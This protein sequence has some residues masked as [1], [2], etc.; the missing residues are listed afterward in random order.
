[1]ITRS[2]LGANVPAVRIASTLVSALLLLVAIGL[3]LTRT[4][5]GSATSALDLLRLGTTLGKPAIT[6][7]S[8]LVVIA[9]LGGVPLGI[10]LLLAGRPGNVLWWS[11]ISTILTIGVT[12]ALLLRGNLG[13]GGLLILA[14][15]A[16]PLLTDRLLA[17]WSRST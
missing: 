5:L 1:M 9:M 6:W 3:P 15:G 17:R 4:G 13:T 14:A 16:I 2:D 11:A 8:R 12:L 10:A 7:A